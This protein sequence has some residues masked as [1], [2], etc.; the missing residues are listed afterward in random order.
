MADE[1]T[2]PQIQRYARHIVMTEVGGEGQARLLASKVLVVGAGGLGSPLVLY[3][4][5]AGVGTIGVVDD[6]TVSLS[7][8][9][10][11]ILHTTPR[12][13]QPK[14]E[15][16]IEAVRAL[17]PAIRVVP[18]QLR[19]N[20]ANVRGLLDQYDL[21]ADGTDN[22]DT[23]FLLNDASYFAKKTLVSGAALR[24]D[25][26]LAT[27]KAHLGEP[28]P[29]YRCVFREPPPPGLVPSCAT[30]GVLGALVGTV[31][32]LQATEVVK[33]LLGIGDSMSG[34]LLIYDGLGTRFRKVKVKRDPH[35]PLCSAEASIRDLSSHA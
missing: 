13:G 23:R 30:G 33:E 22:F 10:R 35:C 21:V 9:Q 16:A 1:L 6:D 31:G 25:G 29:C 15:S 3:L 34:N 5:A 28:H 18:H 14:A 27:Y 7:N 17:D 12:I 2:E 19:L 11:Q 26:Q 20:A 24:F 8:L 4:A 32:S